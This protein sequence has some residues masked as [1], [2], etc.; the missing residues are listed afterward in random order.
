MA[1]L[2]STT[3]ICTSCGE[4]FPA[5]TEF[6]YATKKTKLGLT[7]WCKTCCSI[8]AG[9]KP[10]EKLPK[11]FKRCPDCKEVLPYTSEFF[12]RNRSAGTGLSHYCK[13]CEA[14]RS[15]RYYWTNHERQM[16]YQKARYATHRE[17]LIRERVEWQRENK[18]AYNEIHA[19]F[20]KRHGNRLRVYKRQWKMN[21]PEAV[22]LSGNNY[23]R[24]RAAKLNQA[25]GIHTQADLDVIYEQQNER[26]AYCGIPVFWDIPYDLHVDHIVPIEKGGT[27]SPDNLF[28]ACAECN[29][30]KS[31]Y[32]LS[33]WEKVRGW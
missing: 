22:R 5:T 12:N 20:R 32:L 15:T 17:R 28:I 13:R 4:E 11:G 24:N 9:H 1:N 25:G 23:R 31:I 18:E 10:K 14:E 16:A 8:R 27:G 26:C 3:R 2:D 7:A 19:N 30:E 6:F 29:R 21:H 33:R